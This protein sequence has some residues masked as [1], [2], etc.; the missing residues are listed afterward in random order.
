M[1][2]TGVSG[3]LLV[4]LGLLSAVAPLATDMYLPVFTDLAADLG[5]G[6]AGVQLTLTAF[7]T[8]LALGQL[9][10]GPLSDR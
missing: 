6:A 1:T 7:L 2:R 9:V 4:V 3:P 8:G 5:T 10:I